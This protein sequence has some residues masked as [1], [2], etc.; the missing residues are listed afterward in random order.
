MKE[1]TKLANERMK[2]C[3]TSVII[4]E[5]QTKITMRDHFTL[6]ATAGIQ[7]IDNTKCC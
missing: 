4:R 6:I 2:M 7:K 3:S 1:D 5:M